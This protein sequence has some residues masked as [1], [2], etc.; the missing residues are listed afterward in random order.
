VSAFDRFIGIPYREHGRDTSGC[1]CWGLVC[2]VFRELRQVELPSHA[3]GYVS[4]SDAAAV[5]GL[6]ARG[7]LDWAEVPA[8]Q[9]R[10]FDGVL[11]RR[12]GQAYHIG[13]V[14]APGRMLH[15]NPESSSRVDRY[16]AGLIKPLGFFRHSSQTV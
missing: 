3:D 8:G 7:R 14:V 1:D 4:I 11:M 2:L 9:E 10:A 13:L 5:G 16:R 6:I 12:F 15:V